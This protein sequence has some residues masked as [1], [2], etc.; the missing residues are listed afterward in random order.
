MP[1]V[2]VITPADISEDHV[3]ALFAIFAGRTLADMAGRL[4]DES[5]WDMYRT[6]EGFERLAQVNP[7]RAAFDHG[8]IPG[9]DLADAKRAQFTRV[10]SAMAQLEAEGWT[11]ATAE[12]ALEAHG[13]QPAKVFA[14]VTA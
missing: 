8:E 11:Q 9:D 14:A 13:G 12:A 6:P 3:T 4:A 1:N 10:A 7:L 5:H 2:A